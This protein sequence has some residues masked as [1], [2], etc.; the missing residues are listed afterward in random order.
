MTCRLSVCKQLKLIHCCI[1]RFH[2]STLRGVIT[3]HHAVVSSF[4]R[5]IY[6]TV[7]Y[8]DPA[9]SLPLEIR[10]KIDRKY[11]TKSTGR[12][13]WTDPVIRFRPSSSLPCFLST[14]LPFIPFFLPFLSICSFPFPFISFP[15][16]FFW[17]LGAGL[18]FK[19]WKAGLIGTRLQTF[20]AA[21]KT[22]NSVS[23]CV[24]TN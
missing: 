17:W 18:V 23:A 13:T 7:R 16:P 6:D 22:E 5:V 20:S 12:S 10:R 14:H 4:S 15:S 3:A 8:C 19:L 21:F 11:I 2:W 1:S 9:F 24:H